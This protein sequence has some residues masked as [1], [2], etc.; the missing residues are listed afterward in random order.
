MK[1]ILTTILLFVGFTTY[2]QWSDDFTDGDFTTTPIWSGETANF[3]VDGLNQLHLNAPAATDTSYLSVSSDA[4]ENASWEFFANLDF[5]PSSGN[6]ARVYLVSNN[7]NLKGSLNGYFVMIGNTNDEISLYRQ[8]GTD[9]TEIISGTDDATDLT[10]VNCRIKVTRDAVGNWELLVDNT[11][12]TTFTSEGTV[13]DNTYFSSAFAGVHC[14]YTSTRS[15]KMYFDDFVVTGTAYTDTDLPFV[16]SITSISS[17]EVDVLFNESMDQTTVETVANYNLDNE[18]GTPSTAV[19]DGSDLRLVHLTFTTGFTNNTDYFLTTSNVDDLA[20]NTL[21]NSVD[22]FF[23]FVPEMPFVGDVIIT[24]FMADPAD[25]INLI[26][27]EYVEI[28]NN[29]NKTFDLDGWKIADASSSVTLPSYVLA[30]NEYVLLTE[31]GWGSAYGISNYIEVSLPSYNN[32]ADAVVIKSNADLTLDSL[33]FDLSWYAY[34]DKEDG[35]WSIERKRLSTE[36]SDSYNWAASENVNGGTPGVQNSIFT[37]E[38]DTSAPFVTNYYVVGDTAV[39][40]EFDESVT[41]QAD[42]GWT[43]SPSLNITSTNLISD[44]Q[45]EIITETMA[46]GII[47]KAT[48]SGAQN[49]FGTALTEFTFEFGL[50][51]SV[52]AGDVVINELMFNPLSGG[53]D[54][55]EIVNISDKVLSLKNWKLASIDDDT[56]ANIKTII[57][58]QILFLPG[59]YILVTED[60]TDIANDFS[61]YGIGT[62][63][64]TDIPTYTNDSATVILID[65][66][67]LVLDRV[68]YDEDYHFELLS[69]NKGKAL[70][71][72]SFTADSDSPDNWHTASELVEWGTPGYENSQFID[73]NAVGDI[74]ITTPIFSPDNDGYQDVMI[75]SYQFTNPDNVMD[76]QVYDSEGRL[77]RELKDNFYPGTNGILNWDGINDEGTKAQSGAYV[78]LIIV[79]DLDGNRTVYKEVVVLATRL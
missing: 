22:N 58:E 18:A 36:C 76:V 39:I 34:P 12:G 27:Q 77:I 23:Y 54:Y 8:D 74:T 14:K 46:T 25:S 29:S 61:I 51:D 75:L 66:N 3:E 30:P 28:Y 38:N 2:S 63:I 6:L 26:E 19:Q 41:L 20:G 56:I 78:L 60:S 1:K 65:N 40:V 17:T 37:S 64:E 57:D 73:A 50:P 31:N 44:F 79:F 48:L 68:H 4:I 59:Q 32:S 13:L 21:A 10:S 42:F 16:E 55:I 45:A 71:R 69:T 33:S 7:P 72:I 5:N 35:G 49:C 9:K 47:Y 67:N 11:G 70:E 53:S 24:E 62:F 52:V 43:I 15:D